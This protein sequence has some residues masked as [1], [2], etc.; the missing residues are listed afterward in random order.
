MQLIRAVWVLVPAAWLAWGQAPAPTAPPAPASAADQA[1]ISGTVLNARSS[2]P[3]KRAQITLTPISGTGE[4]VTGIT[5][6]SGKFNLPGITPGTY[7][8]EV[9]RTGFVRP[10]T[11]AADPAREPAILTLQ[12]RQQVADLAYH[13]APGSVL[14]G[15]VTDED[16][17]PMDGVRI[18]CLQYSYRPSGRQITAC[19]FTTTDD[20][21]QYR[22]S[23]L[24]AGRY[25][26]R[27]TYV[28]PASLL[29]IRGGM[30]E[31]YPSL[32][33]PGV[34]DAAQA[35]EIALQ[36]SEER[37]GVDFKLAPA[38]AVRVQGQ[39]RTADG[40]LGSGA[41]VSLAPRMSAGLSGRSPVRVG[42]DGLFRF[43]GVPAGSYM[44]SAALGA[45]RMSQILEVGESDLDNVRLYLSPR[46]EIRGHIR[47]E[48]DRK[49]SLAGLPIYLTPVDDSVLMMAGAGIG[50]VDDA[51]NFLFRAM[52]AGDYQVLIDKLPED[53]FL[54]SLSVGNRPTDDM[55]VHFQ[56]T[57]GTVLD[58]LVSAAGGRVDGTLTDDQ[59]KPVANAT[60]V[61]A[62]DGTRR[63]RGDLYR[64]VTS[65]Q[66]GHFTIRGVV[67]GDYK[68]FAWNDELPAWSWLDPAVLG[69]YESQGKS[70][71]IQENSHNAV[72]LQTIPVSGLP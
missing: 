71:S 66:Y 72:D 4:A 53:A 13:L 11:R 26:V 21:G 17:Q 42:G 64:N 25:Y 16:D 65:D 12:A 61:L 38:R 47:V 45:N 32:F 6:S 59:Q 29:P 51:G 22:I 24:G 55:I 33:Y 63:S 60:V 62:P 41:L 43:E 46:V 67:P 37:V 20:R 68:L 49:L 9:A 3:L 54:K 2:E 56:G 1:A 5:D 48:G 18:Q 36:E 34:K 70:V 15:V 28:D 57:P 8:V 50:S 40:R 7:R 30:P 58:L 10:H 14:A 19:G 52:S 44:L 27:A 23:G 31:A 39:V 69:P 35:G